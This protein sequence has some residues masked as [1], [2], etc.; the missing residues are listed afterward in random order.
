MFRTAM[1]FVHQYAFHLCPLSEPMH[2]ALD[3][4]YRSVH[5]RI[6]RMESC[7]HTAQ[8]LFLILGIDFVQD[9]LST[10]DKVGLTT[11]RDLS[12]RAKLIHD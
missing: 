3:V 11:T 4:A 5:G 10:D 8:C 2:V 9:S 12:T 1:Q 6:P 7:V